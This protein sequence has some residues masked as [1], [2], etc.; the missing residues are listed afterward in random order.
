[1]TRIGDIEEEL[2]AY[3][4]GSLEGNMGLR[5]WLGRWQDHGPT[6]GGVGFASPPE[7]GGLALSAART[8]N[9]VE[10][11]LRHCRAGHARIL[12]AR[13]RPRGPFAPLRAYGELA[14]VLLLLEQEVSLLLADLAQREL[15]LALQS[16][17]A[18]EARMLLDAVEP[19]GLLGRLVALERA[20]TAPTRDRARRARVARARLKTLCGA[21]VTRALE[22]YRE[23]RMTAGRREQ[24]ERIHRYDRSL[25]G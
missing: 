11:A 10:W 24:S 21:A 19:D 6:R 14:G 20:A 25:G 3:F 4:A 23:A 1:M 7:P 18:E 16:G 2:A 8:V 9:R 13:F 12:E 15:R 5:S 17:T 22:D